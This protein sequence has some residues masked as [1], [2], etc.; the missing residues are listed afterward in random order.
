MSIA[1]SIKTNDGL[2]LA[3]DSASTL[4][5]QDPKQGIVV[6]NTYNN[7]NKVFNLVKG[8]PI[9]VVTWGAGSIGLASIA[10]LVKDLRRRLS[11]EVRNGQYKDWVINGD[12]YT[13]LW[14]AEKVRKFIYEENYLQAFKEWPQKPDISF[15]VGGYSSGASLP[16]EYMIQIVKGECGLP[17]LLRQNQETGTTWGGI[18]EALNRLLLGYGSGL[19]QVLQG[20]GI[21]AQNLQ[22]AMNAIQAV[23]GVPLVNP[24]MP[25]QD[26]IDLAQF[27]VDL[28]IKWVRFAPGPPT[29]GGP[30]EIAA[31]SK[32]EGFR[33]VQRKYY[34]SKE[35]NPEETWKKKP[36]A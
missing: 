22:Q 4:L 6:I 2:V 26:A 23:L 21:P 27:F 7:A 1:I 15:I 33:W 13:I 20:V 5:G 14:A 36:E 8:L 9:G 16:D 11:N 31:I 24:A 30:I 28:T 18:G 3:A 34:F 10:T 32:H 29:V 17:Q 19:P 12:N 25:L 35:L